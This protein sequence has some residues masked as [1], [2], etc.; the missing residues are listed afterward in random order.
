MATAVTLLAN[1]IN[2]DT[3]LQAAYDTA[4]AQI[5]QLA[6]DGARAI[7]EPLMSL[8]DPSDPIPEVT[9]RWERPSTALP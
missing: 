6:D 8:P 9:S 5:H 2:D 4:V 3:D 7:D 1:V